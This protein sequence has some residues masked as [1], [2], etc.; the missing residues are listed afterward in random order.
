MTTLIMGWHPPC[1]TSEEPSCT[2]AVG[3]ASL[4]SGVTDGV[5]LSLPEQSSAPATSSALGV[6]GNHSL[7]LANSTCSTQGPLS[8]TS[9]LSLLTQGR[10]VW[11]VCEDTQL[12]GLSSW[13][14]RSGVPSGSHG[15]GC[16]SEGGDTP[17]WPQ[18]SQLRGQEGCLVLA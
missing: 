1:V 18:E 11:S 4:T 7:H 12:T 5:F 3:E 14:P 13:V 17:L 6:S 16:K 9:P 2:G 8:P 10:C 15:L